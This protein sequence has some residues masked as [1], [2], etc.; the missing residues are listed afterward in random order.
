LTLDSK[1]IDMNFSAWSIRNPIPAI[2]LF[3]LLTL[4]GLL[5]FKMMNVQ[6]FP[7][8]ELPLVIVSASLPGAAPAQLET[9][10]VRKLENSIASVPMVKNIFSNTL[11]GDANITVEF[12]LEKNTQEAVN[13]VRD[14]V[15]RVRA[16]LP[17][18]VRDP[19]VSK[20]ST[21]GRPV[22]TYALSSEKLTEQELSW[23]VDNS[24][25]KRVLSEAGVG[26]IKRLGGI[27]REVTV[28]LNPDIMRSFGV[29]AA[30]V[31]RVL[32]AVQ[33]EAPGGRGDVGGLE[34]AVRTIATVKSAA[35]LAELQ[36]NLQDGRKVRLGEIASVRDGDAE[37]RSLALKDGKPIVAF[38]I[39][40]TRGASEVDVRDNVATAV[41]QLAELNPNIK[42]E[43]AIDNAEPVKENYNANM[44]LLYEGALLAVLVV[45]FFLRD[46]RATIVSASALPLSIIPAFIGMYYFGF[47]LN[48][49]TFTS[50]SLVVG[51]L[52]DDAIVEV[53]NIERHLRMGK[54]PF[55]AAMEA[56]DEIGLAVIATTFAL[57][58]VFLPTAF[59][60]GVPGKFF[61][62][63]G[64]TATLAILASLVVARLLTPMMAAYIMKSRPEHRK[65]KP[66]GKI[67]TAYIN[68]VKWCLNYRWATY[69][70]AALF[71][72]GSALIVPLLPTGFVP[73]ADRAQTNVSIELPPGSSLAQ[74]MVAE[75]RVREVLAKQEHIKSTFSSVGGGV[76][77]DAFAI[78]S[79]AEAR[80]AVI[81]VMLSH[82]DKRSI[83]QQE[84]ESVIRAALA[85]QPGVRI[86]VGPQDSGVKMQMVLR[87]ED[88]LALAGVARDVER[89][90][91]TLE[92]IG[93]VSS[94]A[95]LI[96]PEVIVRPDP[97]AA[98]DLG[99]T[100]QAIAETVRIATAGDYDQFLPKL[101]LSE[102]QIPIRV[103]LPK[104]VRGDLEALG[105][106]MVPSARGPVR[107]DSVAALTIDGGPSQ[108][109][110]MNRSRNVT[111][112][113]ELGSRQLGE[114]DT[115]AKQL[116]SIK[117]LPPNVKL[118][119]LGDA[120][121][122]GKLFISFA[123]AM[124][125]GILCI[126]MVLVLLFKDFFQ[127]FTILAALPLAFGGAFVLLLV[128]KNA[129][130]MPSLIGLIMLMGVVTKNSI[131][132]VEYAIVARRPGPN[133]EPGMDRFEAL[134]DACH[135]RGR[136][137]IMTSIAMIAGMLPV[138]IGWAGDP[139]FNSPM[140]IAVIGGLVTS[141]LLSLLVVPAVYTLVDD[142]ETGL[143][144]FKPQSHAT[145]VAG[146]TNAHPVVG[147]RLL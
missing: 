106:L 137:I 2:L 42:F 54:S 34:Q 9:E 23:F 61:K 75:Q 79:A 32:R 29:S 46:W 131:L 76:T 8:V 114:L 11:D 36:I 70:L 105:Q 91:R 5:S 20:V 12:E 144:R 124:L 26:A 115:E 121:E 134:V 132:L 93:N 49:V 138:A 60:G 123:I 112:D 35:E 53:E 16:D 41:K 89:D 110:R 17:A 63:F 44:R 67:M 4:A 97:A 28:E 51:I 80:K 25:A 45:W 108:I 127:P 135:K 15:A 6:D 22:V 10:V 78:G 65:P 83:K 100:T 21:A 71:F 33:L 77:G 117:N 81:T 18:D 57:V 111:F 116:P 113:V 50:L 133:G 118:A 140:A 101:N 139:S 92:G 62:Q 66:D 98:A 96:R 19:I 125:I 31:S 94:T 109:D 142:I 58:A 72:V 130:S 88:P 141:T 64:W 13:D 146:E 24:V 129:F 69:G 43:L 82:R 40:R 1:D 84:L 126:Y 104:A 27:N 95:S 30:D 103:K 59:M 14:A 128:T 147:E 39:A 120:A 145:T 56:A 102:R 68:A 90:L 73:P 3:I 38:E 55:Q 122:M 7:D 37:R 74:T 136:P 87:S 119:E 47:T 143:A 48:V 86:A 52:V 107:L 85:D 99:V